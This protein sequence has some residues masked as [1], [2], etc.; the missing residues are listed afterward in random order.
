MLEQQGDRWFEAETYHLRG[1]LLLR[2]SNAPE[3]SVEAWLR[4][5]L[6]VARSQQAKSM[7]LR[8]ATPLARLWRVQ[9]KHCGE[10]R[11]LLSPLYG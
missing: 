11:D 6:D 7:E 2:Q 3:A 1:E 9:A 4:R 5:A 8:A 10:V